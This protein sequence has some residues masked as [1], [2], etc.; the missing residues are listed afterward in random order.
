M[1]DDVQ[2]AKSGGGEEFA[3]EK[4]RWNGW[5][6]REQ[7]FDLEGRD[8][9][10]WTYLADALGLEALPHTPAVALE[11][12]DLQEGALDEEGRRSLEEAMGGP[13]GVKTDRME[14]LFH[15]VGKSYHDMIRIRRG[16]VPRAPDVV[17]YPAS[18]DQVAAALGWAAERGWAVV[19]YGG[20]SSVV[21][22]V[23]PPVGERWPGVMTLDT[24]RLDRL[25]EIDESSHTARFEA[26]IYGPKLERDLHER[27]Y[28][29]G[30]YPQSWEFSTLGG[31][32]AARG[33]GQQSNRYGSSDKFLVAT[34]LQTPRGQW[35]IRG[36][37]ASAAGPNLNQMV[38]GSEGT[39]GVIVDATVKVHELAESSDYR[40]YLFKDFRSG[41]EA[42][43][44]IVQAEIPVAMI[45]LS[46]GD[47]TRFFSKFKSIGHEDDGGALRAAI[48]KVMEWTGYGQHP[49]AMLIGLE[50]EAEQVRVS[51]ARTLAVCLKQGALPL[52]AG[53]GRSWYEGRFQMPYLRDPLMDRGVGVDTL[54][55]STTW[56][57]LH[58]L[59]RAVRD[60]IGQA[61]EARGLRG[62]VLGHISHSYL[63]G[64]SL[65]FTFVFPRDLDDEL[66]QWREI[67]QAASDVIAREGGT[68]SHH[69]GVGADHLDWMEAEKGTLGLAVL[70]GARAAIDPAG[71]MNPG[72]LIPPTGEGSSDEG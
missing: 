33:A 55:T 49:C 65:Y 40:G 10:L 45:R 19:P 69:H 66:G 12:V 68:I 9:A 38:A 28:T 11:E 31:W 43:R 71:I 48:K 5:G 2:T 70:Q 29:L 8:E 41:A 51:Q 26:G 16:E 18:A 1:A 22:G 15:A 17:V 3:R 62:L 72:K 30:H 14:R 67:K 54:E 46:D 13:E 20:G 36:F 42:I 21:G 4:L 39:M 44:Q 24:S 58:H 56:S 47:E 53:P 61:I 63:V 57:N 64:A 35:D 32:I 25:L 23:E 37:P 27:G 50:G 52:G 6:W 34:T 60:A 59:H 7:G